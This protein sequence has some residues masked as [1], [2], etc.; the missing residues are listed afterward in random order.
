MSDALLGHKQL[1]ELIE[2]RVLCQKQEWALRSLRDTAF[3]LAGYFGQDEALPPWLKQKMEEQAQEMLK[4]I[5][6]ALSEPP[7]DL[8]VTGPV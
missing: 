7:V 4:V 8:T 1:K 5:S 3:V 6:E 2:L